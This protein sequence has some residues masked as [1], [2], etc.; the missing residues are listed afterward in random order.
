M[1]NIV[2][3]IITNPEINQNKYAANLVVK[4]DID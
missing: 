1:Q 3:A 4:I 2:R